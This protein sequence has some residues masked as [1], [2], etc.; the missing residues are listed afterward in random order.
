V[1]V[2]VNNR[3]GYIYIYRRLCSRCSLKGTVHFGKS[4]RPNN[5][6]GGVGTPSKMPIRCL[7]CLFEPPAPLT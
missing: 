1:I 3:K 5:G 2:F 6:G 7:P 4:R